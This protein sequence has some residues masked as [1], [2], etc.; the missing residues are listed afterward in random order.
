MMNPD[1]DFDENYYAYYSDQE[2]DGQSGL[3]SSLYIGGQMGG[4]NRQGKLFVLSGPSGVGKT[5]LAGMLFEKFGKSHN[6]SRVITYTTKSP[7]VG[8]QN[9]IDYFFIPVLEFES[10]LAAGFFIEHSEAYGNYYG[11]PKS[12][13]LELKQG[14]SFLLVVDQA[15]AYSIKKQYAQAVLIW[16]TPPST[17]ELVMRLV[18]RASD[19]PADIEKRLAIA[20]DEL[21]NEQNQQLFDYVVEN[22]LLSQT[23]SNLGM[24]IKAETSSGSTN[25]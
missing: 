6:L 4:K 11:S 13:L 17:D 7:R 21:I 22:N 9:G 16:L 15:G 8:E 12:I 3:I 2:I 10:K 14:K 20:A 25:C 24:I 19:S 23:V 5:T 18:N 1:C